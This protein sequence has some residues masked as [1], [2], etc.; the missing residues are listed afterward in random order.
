MN[1]W[2]TQHSTE[3]MN[4]SQ[5]IEQDR[6]PLAEQLLLLTHDPERWAVDIHYVIV[7]GSGFGVVLFVQHFVCFVYFEIHSYWCV[8]NKFIYLKYICNYQVYLI[9]YLFTHT[10]D[11][12]MCIVGILSISEIDGL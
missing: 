4:E 2:I 12:K 3:W 9:Y 1:E 7:C 11:R 5:T 8:Q 10:Y 6:P